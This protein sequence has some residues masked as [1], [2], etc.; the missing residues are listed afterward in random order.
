MAL[1]D[2][3]GIQRQI[4]DKMVDKEAAFTPSW[5]GPVIGSETRHRLTDVHSGPALG[6]F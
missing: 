6:R 1:I 5:V 3:A 4:L 2:D